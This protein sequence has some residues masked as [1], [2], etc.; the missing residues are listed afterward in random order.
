MNLKGSNFRID[1]LMILLYIAWLLQLKKFP[2]NQRKL[3]CELLT[4]ESTIRGLDDLE[5]IT[6]LTLHFCCP[7]LGIFVYLLFCSVLFS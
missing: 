5:I 6:P 7:Y 1:K 3:N 4:P 2:Y